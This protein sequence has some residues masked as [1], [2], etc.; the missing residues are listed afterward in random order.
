MRFWMPRY[1]TWTNNAPDGAATYGGCSM[2]GQNTTAGRLR[3]SVARF[4]VI[5]LVTLRFRAGS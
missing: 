1:G 2:S 4:G 5:N 3:V